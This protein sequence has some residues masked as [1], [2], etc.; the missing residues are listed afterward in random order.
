MCSVPSSVKWGEIVLL[1]LLY[2]LSHTKNPE[3]TCHTKKQLLSNTVT[4]IGRAKSNEVNQM[5]AEQE[6]REKWLKMRSSEKKS[7]F[8]KY[9]VKRW[10]WKV[11]DKKVTLD[12]TQAMLYVHK[13]IFLSP[14]T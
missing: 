10:S 5:T 12:V 14:W 7:V 4:I 2:K 8:P 9:T 3:S 6:K 1:W 11:C 13:P